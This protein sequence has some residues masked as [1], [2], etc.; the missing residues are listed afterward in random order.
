MTLARDPRPSPQVLRVTR[1]P[2]IPWI[3]S[4][5]ITQ[6]QVGEVAEPEETAGAA[7]ASEE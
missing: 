3:R 1:A 4:L 7:E 6:M 5:A 2:Q